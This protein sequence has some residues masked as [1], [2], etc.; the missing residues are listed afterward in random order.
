MKQLQNTSDLAA[1]MPRVL[2]NAIEVTDSLLTNDKDKNVGIETV[3]EAF[4]TQHF[5]YDQTGE[6][7][8]NTIS[9]YIKS[10]RG[11][12]PDAAVYYLS[13]MLEAGEDVKFVARRLIVLASEDIGKR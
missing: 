6:E 9:A 7:H 1:V 2:L 13:R 12:D 5:R 4:Q 3:K 11:S 10:V 8:Y